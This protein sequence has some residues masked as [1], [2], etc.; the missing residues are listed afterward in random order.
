MCRMCRPP[1]VDAISPHVIN[2]CDNSL[3][4]QHVTAIDAW[5]RQSDE[6]FDHVVL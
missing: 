3:R 4:L 2:Y 1:S 5:D 6:C